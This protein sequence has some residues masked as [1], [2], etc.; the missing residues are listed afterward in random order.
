MST[1]HHHPCEE[2]SHH[3]QTGLNNGSRTASPD[4]APAFEAYLESV[5]NH[6]LPFPQSHISDLIV[7]V[8]DNL[9]FLD[10]CLPYPPPLL[11]PTVPSCDDR[12][13]L[14]PFDPLPPSSAELVPFWLDGAICDFFLQ[15]K[16]MITVGIEYGGTTVSPKPIFF[17]RGSR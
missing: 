1:N 4:F 5:L 8:T 10:H 2:R 13:F 3:R 9:S 11:I 16:G 6:F 7:L 12:L 15:R 17:N 14:I